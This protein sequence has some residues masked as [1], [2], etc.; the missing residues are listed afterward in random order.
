[1]H[2]GEVLGMETELLIMAE[3]ELLD[4]TEEITD[5]QLEV[6]ILVVVEVELVDLDQP[7]QP[8]Q[9]PVEVESR[10]Q[11]QGQMLIMEVV[12]VVVITTDPVEL[13]EL[14]EEEGVVMVHLKH[15]LL[16]KMVH[17]IR[18]EEVV[19]TVTW[20]LLQVVSRVQ[21]VQVLSS[22]LTLLK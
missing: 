14:V 8:P 15:L 17:Q 6:V 21:V 12:E 7:E 19:Q 10:I 4:I 13:V 5:L 11:L 9:E 3:L 16:G 1:M 2:P 22:S 20:A 18:V